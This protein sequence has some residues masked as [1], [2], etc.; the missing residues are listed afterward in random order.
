MR[1]T[2]ALLALLMA[3][4]VGLTGC[5]IG[6]QEPEAV[7]E[8]SLPEPTEEP[9]NMILGEALSNPYSNVTFYFPAE[10]LTGFSTVTRSIRTEAGQS[11]PEAAVK[12]LL[13]SAEEQALRFEQER[14][15]WQ[16]EKERVLRYQRE[17]QGGYMDMYRRNQV[18]EQEL[19]ALREPPA[20]WSPRLESSKI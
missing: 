2:L 1:R 6:G 19:R 8:I 5:G 17:I 9:E 18:L 4:A 10:D 15:T 3:L 12:A 13:A 16:E 14:R 11:M 20:P 7:G